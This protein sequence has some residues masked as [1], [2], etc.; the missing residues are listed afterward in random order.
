MFLRKVLGAP[1]LLPTFL[2]LSPL[3][4]PLSVPS[5]SSQVLMATDLVDLFTDLS[6]RFLDDGLEEI[7]GPIIRLLCFHPSLERPEGL[8]GGDSVWRS[9]LAALETLVS[10]KGVA[11]VIT[12]LDEWC[13]VNADP[14]QFEHRSLMGPL[15]RL[16][17]FNREW[18]SKFDHPSAGLLELINS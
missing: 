14:A 10:V 8:G 7:V 12:R 6:S 2:S 3:F 17:V 5:S 9:V 4:S 11:S 16:G 1:E 15:L 18:V 13:P